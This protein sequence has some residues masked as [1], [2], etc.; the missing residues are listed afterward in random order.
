MTLIIYS[1][2]AA[3][4][5]LGEHQLDGDHDFIDLAPVLSNVIGP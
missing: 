3:I 2:Q 1:G 5:E 4:G